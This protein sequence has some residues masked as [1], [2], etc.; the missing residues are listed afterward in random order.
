MV[1]ERRALTV[2]PTNRVCTFVRSVWQHPANRGRRARQLLVASRFQA[3]ARLTGRSTIVRLGSRSRIYATLDR[4]AAIQVAFANPPDWREWLVW[5]RQLRP[6]DLFLDVGA[7]VGT[8]TV[9]GAELGARVVAFEPDDDNRQRLVAN[10]ALNGYA[11][12]VRSCALGAQRGSASFTNDLDSLNHLAFHAEP[13]HATTE[14]A[15]E[16]IDALFPTDH[17]AGIKVDVEGAE[18]FVVQGGRRALLEG[19]IGLLQLEW[20]FMSR[21]HYDEERS[22][23]AD[24]LRECG[25][26]LYR[27]GDNGVLV[28]DD[29]ME[30]P[31][32]VFA[33]RPVVA[34]A[35]NARI[36]RAHSE[37]LTSR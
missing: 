30:G 14:V 7:N 11:A 17:I 19:R 5:Q 3:R 9:L 24:I 23:T 20:N 10:L 13:A 37:R 16:T 32:D 27:P 25:Y 18:R 4:P 2:R 31:Q 8:Y 28:P 21:V 34:D 1:T 6:G 26:H 15:V 36:V 29:G 35:L 33:A 12:D 22:L